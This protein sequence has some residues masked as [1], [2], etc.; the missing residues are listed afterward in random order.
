MDRLRNLSNTFRYECPIRV[1][2]VTY[3]GTC[4]LPVGEGWNIFFSQSCQNCSVDPASSI[5][6]RL[7]SLKEVFV[8]RFVAVTNSNQRQ[9]GQQRYQLSVRLYFRVLEALLVT[10]RFL[11]VHSTT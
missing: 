8:R 9:L 2:G 4:S 5:L 3:S 1:R 7:V 11:P 10:V 6:E